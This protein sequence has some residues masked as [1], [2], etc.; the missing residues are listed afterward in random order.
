MSTNFTLVIQNRKVTGLITYSINQQIFK[1]KA[2]T[3]PKQ[4][5]KP[6]ILTN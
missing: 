3:G 1:F 2:T 5:P 4:P 6:P